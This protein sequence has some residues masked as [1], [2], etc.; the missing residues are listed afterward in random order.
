MRLPLSDYDLAQFEA[1]KTFKLDM[2]K[3]QTKQI[4][5]NEAYEEWAKKRENLK[6]SS[7]NSSS[8]AARWKEI[9]DM[10]LCMNGTHSLSEIG[11]YR[12]VVSP[13]EEYLQETEA[14]KTLS[15]REHV[16][17]IEGINPD[18]ND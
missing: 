12:I 8:Y 10:S 1:V 18:K 2:V 3:N 17:H 7:G 14:L 5:R 9:W 13:N 6:D 16:R 15:K 11:M 4:E